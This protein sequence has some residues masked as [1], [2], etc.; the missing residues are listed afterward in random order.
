[1]LILGMSSGFVLEFIHF[2]TRTLL[3]GSDL[4]Y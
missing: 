4:L 1:M 2:A 3:T